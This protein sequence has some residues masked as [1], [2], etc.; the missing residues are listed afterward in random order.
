MGAQHRLHLSYRKQRVYTRL[1][2]AL[3]KLKI[4]R[5]ERKGKQIHRKYA[6]IDSYSYFI[7]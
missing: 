6:V 7:E 2:V 4:Y 1:L 3:Y 5:K